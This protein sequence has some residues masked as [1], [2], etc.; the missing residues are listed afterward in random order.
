MLA[1]GGVAGM[2][3]ELGRGKGMRERAEMSKA[4]KKAQEVR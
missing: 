1:L 3:E 2:E 4:R